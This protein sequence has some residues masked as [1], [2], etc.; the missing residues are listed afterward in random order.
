D[1]DDTAEVILALRAAR[2]QDDGARGAALARALMALFGQQNVLVK[3]EDLLLYEYDGGVDTARPDAVVIPD[4]ASDVAKLARFCHEHHVPIVPRGAGTG[5]S[6][7]AVPVE[8]GVVLSF[9]KLSRIRGLDPANLRA[10]VEPGL[11]NLHL[12]TA[13]SP[14]GLHF[15]PD[16][17]S[18][19]ACTI[20]GNVAENSGGP[21][22]LAYGVTTNHVTG[23][24]I[25]LSDGTV[26]RLG[27]KRAE[28]RGYDLVGAFVGSEGTLGVVTEATLV[29]TPRPEAVLTALAAFASTG[30]ASEAVSAVIGAGVV[31]AAIEMMDHLAIQAVEAAVHAGYPLDAGAVLLVDVEGVREGLDALLD[32]ITTICRD[33]GATEVRLAHSTTERELL[34]AG[35]KGAFGAMGRLAPDYYVQD[36]VIPRTK[37]PEVLAAIADIGARHELRVANV[38]HAGDGNLHPLILF[39]SAVPGQL[40]R[41]REAGSEILRVCLDAGGTLTGE[42]GIGMEKNCQM[43]WQFDDQDLATMQRLRRAFDPDGLANPGKI[44]PTPSRCVEFKAGSFQRRGS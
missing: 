17:S 42:H 11:V 4:D 35:R 18:Q 44:F 5:L 39:D 15:V 24:E 40:D 21:H 27:G 37:L 10:V 43:E 7:G 41:V 3:N 6:G 34:W 16:P 31:P 12:S 32:R 1:I 2:T 38:F 26:T 29:L 13:A 25:V 14:L 22:T 9:A 23:L 19:K 33:A 28:T 36:G 30:E 20:G 8:G